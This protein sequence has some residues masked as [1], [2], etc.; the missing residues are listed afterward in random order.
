[1][2]QRVLASG[3]CGLRRDQRRQQPSETP[4]SFLDYRRA[5]NE[6]SP[7]WQKHKGLWLHPTPTEVTSKA[8]QTTKA[9]RK[10]GFC[11]AG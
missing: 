1:M 8:S 3:N 5:R 4:S 6:H 7:V 11:Q 9:Y 2:T 10:R